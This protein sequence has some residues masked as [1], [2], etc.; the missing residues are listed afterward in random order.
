MSDTLGG[1]CH[2]R[3][4]FGRSGDIHRS[5]EDIHPGAREIHRD[6][7]VSAPYMTQIK[8][9][10]LSRRVGANI[11]VPVET[12]GSQLVHDARYRR[13][14]CARSHFCQLSRVRET[15]TMPTRGA[16]EKC[17]D[18]PLRSNRSG[19]LNAPRSVRSRSRAAVSSQCPDKDFAAR[20]PGLRMLGK[21][22]R[23]VYADSPDCPL[24]M[25]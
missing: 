12:A 15:L 20:L 19:N 14:R 2:D 11:A 4:G 22:R 8:H 23:E 10:L 21:F 6:P 25:D 18:T 1:G 24:W 17:R 16:I 13:S 9:W 5:S 7:G 3:G